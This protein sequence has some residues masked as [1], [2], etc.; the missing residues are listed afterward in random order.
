MAH[1]RRPRPVHSRRYRQ[2]SLLNRLLFR[3]PTLNPLNPQEFPMPSRR[4]III[5]TVAT[6]SGDIATGLA[7]AAAAVWIIETAAFGLFLSFLIWL[8]AALAALALS[9][10]VV[11]P[12]LTVVLSDQKLDLA[13]NAVTSLADR[14]TAFARSTLQTV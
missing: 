6:V 9:Q 8:L 11:H 3:L 7:V 4:N 14:L 12:A 1:S 2:P 10:Y 5:R 13:V